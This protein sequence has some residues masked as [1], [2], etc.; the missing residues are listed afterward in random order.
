MSNEERPRARMKILSSTSWRAHL[1]H[2]DFDLALSRIG[3]DR[4]KAD[5]GNCC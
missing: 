5:S 2:T 3:V 4:T 1:A